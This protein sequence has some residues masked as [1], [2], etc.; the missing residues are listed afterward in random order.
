MHSFID[1]CVH[2]IQVGEPD[3]LGDFVTGLSPNTLLRIECWL[4]GRQIF[5]M[6][7]NM[8]LHKKRNLISSVPSGTVYIEPNMVASEPRQHVIQRFQESLRISSVCSHQPLFPQ[9]RG[10]PPKQIEPFAMLTL[11]WYAKSVSYPGP[12]SAQTRMKTKA[13]LV[14]K[15]HRLV[16]LKALKFF[17]T[18]PRTCGHLRHELECRCSRLFSG[19]IL[20]YAST[21]GP[22]ELSPL[23]PSAPSSGSSASARPRLAAIVRILAG[24]SVGSVPVASAHPASVELVAPC[25]A[26]APKPESPR[27]SRHEYNAPKPCDLARVDW[28]PVPAAGPPIPAIERRSLCRPS[29]PCVFR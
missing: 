4:V 27:G 20:A 21:S 17:L 12:A 6:K 8:A 28:S 13:S 2:G 22:D 5:K 18:L 16:G 14:L 10:Y 24:S 3:V 11:S 1:T 25:E 23:L 9:Q 29:L 19:Y 15:N 26:S 7:L